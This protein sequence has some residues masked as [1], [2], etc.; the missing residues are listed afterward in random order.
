MRAKLKRYI[1][2]IAIIF[3]ILIIFSSISFAATCTVTDVQK[4]A[5]LANKILEEAKEEIIGATPDEIKNLK[6]ALKDNP[7]NAERI[8]S[9]FK[10]KVEQ[11][12]GLQKGG[13]YELPAGPGVPKTVVMPEGG[14]PAPTRRAVSS[15]GTKLEASLIGAP[16]IKEI[17]AGESLG[18]GAFAET[19]DFLI[20]EANRPELAKLLLAMKAANVEF[21][22][23]GG[24]SYDSVVPK[25]TQGYLDYISSRLESLKRANPNAPE[26]ELFKKISLNDL[27]S[28]S[29]LALDKTSADYAKG[30]TLDK[31]LDIELAVRVVDPKRAGK[32]IDD[33]VK[34]IHSDAASAGVLN[35]SLGEVFSVGRAKDSSGGDVG[36]VVMRK[37]KGTTLDNLM[38]QGFLKNKENMRYFA[39]DMVSAIRSMDSQGLVHLDIKPSNIMVVWDAA[40]QRPRF[41]LI[42]F[43]IMKFKD[44]AKMGSY[45]AEEIFGGTLDYM[46]PEQ[47]KR[48]SSA[49]DSRS[50]IFS[51]GLIIHE[52]LK[53]YNLNHDIAS[54]EPG[55]TA[56]SPPSMLKSISDAWGSGKYQTEL[57][58]A[59]NDPELASLL[60]RDLQDFFK[61]A[62]SDAK[63]TRQKAL[64][65]TIASA[66]PGLKSADSLIRDLSSNDIL[67]RD[68]A[69]NELLLRGKADPYEV[70][71]KL[72]DFLS[73]EVPKLPDTI[74]E[75]VRRQVMESIFEIES[76]RIQ[77][78]ERILAQKRIDR[79]ILQLRDK[80][81]LKI[82][83]EEAS[84]LSAEEKIR[85][86]NS[87]TAKKLVE[88]G[89]KKGLS[90]DEISK[91][92][93][94]EQAKLA[95]KI[96]LS[97][98]EKLGLIDA[99]LV[100]ANE[101][102]EDGGPARINNYKFG[103]KLGKL[104]LLR[105]AGF[106][107]EERRALMEEGIAGIEDTQTT[108]N[109][110]ALKLKEA[111]D[112]KE[113]SAFKLQE[114]LES[115]AK[116]NEEKVR[117]EVARAIIKN[118]LSS[119]FP[120][121]D[122]AGVS[123]AVDIYLDISGGK[124]V[125][126]S[127]AEVLDYCGAEIKESVKKYIIELKIT[128]G[129][130]AKT[131]VDDIVGKVL[132]GEIK[133]DDLPAELF[134]ILKL[135]NSKLRN[136]DNRLPKIQEN[137]NL[138]GNINKQV[139]DY[140]KQSDAEKE[141]RIRIETVSKT[142]RG[143]GDSK[144]FNFK[145]GSYD[146]Q[147]LVGD[148]ESAEYA[149]S[150]DGHFIGRHV[151]GLGSGGAGAITTFFTGYGNVVGTGVHSMN[152]K[153]KSGEI[154]SLPLAE[155]RRDILSR[156]VRAASIGEIRKLT[157]D[158]LTKTGR[159]L[160]S[161]V[162]LIRAEIDGQ[163]LEIYAEKDPKIKAYR[164]VQIIP[165]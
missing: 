155:V 61:N 50:A 119:R 87:E 76:E 20:G 148:Y 19:L 84:K 125:D 32:T 103:Q 142:G 1:P 146:F 162:V 161:D 91:Q 114:K 128:L 149:Y 13:T 134:K 38:T 105:K 131:K 73:S 74:R 104:R 33:V 25:I 96:I 7:V 135:D 37:E 106:I 151:L 102:G 35:P 44:A 18:K 100:G 156:L 70:G 122:K 137:I 98:R 99:H 11:R 21:S 158:E 36:I 83:D 10:D 93:L 112:A 59:I 80:G 63:T 89:R 118:I 67:A 16:G 144:F 17:A 90:D 55:F 54:Q 4:R 57:S 65:A 127:L 69:L 51:V 101:L 41:R 132:K 116:Y 113:I 8:I 95:D 52:A 163:I 143:T 79:E 129:D 56:G 141:Y 71:P 42:D 60:P 72:M 110:E 152:V 133:Y 124:P 140:L 66:Q 78:A 88:E 46:S 15:A 14:S 165:G 6:T 29:N 23:R 121:L 22:Q 58:R 147:I 5:E 157:S 160:G 39:Q 108:L 62:L 123:D 94:D 109:R 64:D 28:G 120:N 30:Y 12:L 117:D 3:L 115:V 43:G 40:A 9:E 150:L 138:F 85:L 126:K 164:I 139:D 111:F 75:D 68:N 49:T 107:E 154:N 136:N 53:G 97:D 77:K 159:G 82:T 24:D 31:L 86:I 2:A 48:T 153:T 145:K 81:R 92:I 27:L 47:I 45:G 26:A 34:S 130:N